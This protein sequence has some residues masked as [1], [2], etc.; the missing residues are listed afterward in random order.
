[1]TGSAPVTDG[2]S[3]SGMHVHLPLFDGP[4]DLLYYLIRKHELNVS[5]ISLAVIAD[6]FV[7]AVEAA[8]ELNLAGAGNFL[9]IAAT[10]MHLKSKWLLPPDEE[11]PGGDEQEQV[12]PLLQQLADLQKFREI[13]H[14]LSLQEDRARAAFS[15]PLTSDLARR[16]DQ[17]AEQEPY[18][19]M[20]A[21]E[22]LK[23]MR[24]IQEF[25]FPPA[26]EIAREEINLEDKITELL[27]IIKIRIQV[28]L[29]RLLNA[30]RSSL[31]TAVTFLAAL[32][33]ARLKVLRLRQ[34]EN[35]GQIS[36]TAREGDAS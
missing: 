20:S 3:F 36:A 27:A 15:R 33:L 34:T 35:F 10:L 1:M 17:I 28:S 22:L 16:L 31:E 9:V 25:A 21:F 13:V 11:T 5:E 29:S 23:S 8:R 30:C 2:H 24:Q 26:R 18:I 32:E 14:D 19:E 4:L 7:A 6:E 12:G